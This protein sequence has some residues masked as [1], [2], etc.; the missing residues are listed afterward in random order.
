VEDAGMS[1]EIKAPAPQT[2]SMV[3]ALEQF[4]AAGAK[5]NKNNQ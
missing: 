2:P 3:A 4:L 1:L 5:N